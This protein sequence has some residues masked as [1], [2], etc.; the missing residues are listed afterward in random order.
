MNGDL[1][2]KLRR[3]YPFTAPVIKYDFSSSV[4]RKTMICPFLSWKKSER[5][6]CIYRVSLTKYVVLHGN[7]YREIFFDEAFGWGKEHFF[8]KRRVRWRAC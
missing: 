4:N 3:K 5:K 6:K 7:F 1:M 2:M 8:K